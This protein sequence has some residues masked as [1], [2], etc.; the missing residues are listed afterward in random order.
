MNRLHVMFVMLIILFSVPSAMA[1]TVD[2]VRGVGEWDENWAYAQYNA[3]SYN[4]YASFGDRMVVRQGVYNN[5]VDLVTDEWNDIDPKDDSGGDFDESMAVNG[6]AATDYSSGLD[7]SK[8]Y[9]HYDPINDILYGMTEVYGIPGDGDGNGEIYSEEPADGDTTAGPAGSGIGLTESWVI[10]IIQV[11]TGD[12][13]LILVNANAW[14]VSSSVGMTNSD[15]YAHLTSDHFNVANPDDLPKSVY[16][17]SISDFSTFYDVSPGEV[18]AVEVLSGSSGDSSVGEDTAV[19]FI[20]IPNPEIHIEKATNGVDADTYE[21]APELSLGQDVTW[22]YVVT[23]TGNVPLA[24]V[25]VTDDQGVIPVFQ[26]GDTDGDGLLDLTETWTYEAE[27]T[28]ECGDYENVADVVGYYGVIPVTDDDPSH[29]VVS[30][31]PDIDIEKSTNGFDADFPSG[32]AI[33]VGETITWKYVVTNT[34]DAALTNIVVVDDVIGTIG[35]DKITDK[36][37]GDDVLEIG[38]EWTYIVTDTLEECTPLYKNTGNVTGE[39]VDD[40]TVVTDEDPSH[41]HCKS[42]VPT[43]TPVGILAMIGALG[44]LGMVTLRRRD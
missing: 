23:N 18:L 19:V 26:G 42:V 39:A 9:G 35:N 6:V 1:I 8:I 43:L 41:Y 30:C 34:G 13:S 44:I 40:G 31:E 24:D 25:E 3:S 21:E 20:E 38:E 4:P 17:I 14:T 22:T 10:R 5:P 2:G 11:S 27:G 12:S 28:A 37:D 15:V 32:P 36:A 29:Y 33:E 7:V 16:E